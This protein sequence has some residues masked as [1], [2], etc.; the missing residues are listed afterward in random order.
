MS[1]KGGK[2]GLMR[3]II[4][5]SLLGITLLPPLFPFHCWAEV[6]PSLIPVSLLGRVLLLSYSRFTVGQEENPP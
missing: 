1:V 2:G 3:L 4:P 5:V 6:S